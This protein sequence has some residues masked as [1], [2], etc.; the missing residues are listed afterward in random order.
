MN[1]MGRSEY[2]VY[3][4]EYVREQNNARLYDAWMHRLST[5]YQQVIRIIDSVLRFFLLDESIVCLTEKS[6]C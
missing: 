4:A 2:S 1:K 6:S 3:A 5:S